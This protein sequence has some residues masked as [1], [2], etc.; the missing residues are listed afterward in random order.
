MNILQAIILGITQGI[1][2]FLPIS[3]SGHLVLLQKIF[4][5]QEPSMTFDI[6]LHLGTLVAVF[7]VFREKIM[8]LIKHPCQKYFRLII[9]STIPAVLVALILHNQITMMFESGK[10]LAIAFFITGTLLMYADKKLESNNNKKN[11][12][13]ISY[14]DAI[15][16]GILQA[17]AIAP[18][19]SRS[20]S[21][22]SSS[23]FCGLD[24]NTAAK[25]SFILSIPAI[26]GAA[27]LELKNVFVNNVTTNISLAVFF[28]GFIFAMISG[29][30]SIKFMI[31]LIQKSKLR[32]F[33]YYTWALCLLIFI[34]QTFTKIFF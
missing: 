8:D 13:S 2:E 18:G 30:F 34:D 21:T 23:I 14:K 5:I 16:I 1:T 32:I 4:N 29:Y 6:V 17:I 33:A 25:F 28:F 20:G 3:S 15:N 10:Y 22:I 24:N 7:I 12:E 27:I 31:Q 11:D 9:I 19:I 26:L